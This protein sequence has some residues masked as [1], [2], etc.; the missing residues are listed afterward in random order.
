MPRRLIIVTRGDPGLYHYIRSDWVGDETVTVMTDRRRAERRQR[1]EPREPD[2]RRGDRRQHCL[3]AAM[4]T[5]GWAAVVLSGAA[6]HGAP[7]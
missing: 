1:T 6:R 7:L 2:R 5:N 3:D 4:K